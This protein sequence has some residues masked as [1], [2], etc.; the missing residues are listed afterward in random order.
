MP[1]K[2]ILDCDPGHDDAVAILLAHGSPEIE[3]LAV[4]TVVGNQTLAKVTRNAL[5]VARIAGITDVPFAAGADRP[6]V[7]TIEHAADIHGESGLD[8]PVLPEPSIELDPRHAVDL[9]IDTVMAHEPGTITLVPVGGLTNI[10]LAVRKEPRIVERVQR[11]VL[12]GGGVHVGNMTPVAEF[13]IAID[14]EAA[15]IVFTAGWDVVMV[16]LDLTHQALAT[17]DIVARIAALG[18][19]PARFVD[20]LTGFFADAYRDVQGFDAPPVHD[21]CAVAHVIDPT[22][23]RAV[24]MPIAVETTGTLTTGMTVAD[25]RAPAPEDCRTSAALELDRDRF[26]DLVVDALERIGEGGVGAADPVAVA[27]GIDA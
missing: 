9:I 4:T 24:R 21:P 1:Q 26:W 27:D 5:A 2:I 15:Q 12:M 7:R 19:G 3:L 22:I 11:V 20:E 18:T 8:G 23:V 13:N 10:A 25:L 14:P 16:G 6:L 17:P